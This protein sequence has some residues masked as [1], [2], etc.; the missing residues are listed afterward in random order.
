MS[1]SKTLI[2]TLLAAFMMMAAFF[3]PMTAYA[4][5]P[6]DPV[7]TFDFEGIEG[8]DG[9]DLSELLDS[10]TLDELLEMF[11]SLDFSDFDIE[12]YLNETPTP[13]PDNSKPFTP[14]GQASVLDLA[15][16]G[17]GKMFYTF[18][19]PAGNV[20]YLIIDRQRGGDNVYF[21]SAVTEADLLGLI[22]NANGKGGTST[23][24]IP[25]TPN[26]STPN[27]DGTDENKD[28]ETDVDT[29][30]KKKNNNGMLIFLLI[31]AVAVGGAGYYIKIVRPKQNAGMDDDEDD[32]P[33]EDDG[34]EMEFEDEANE[35]GNEY[36]YTA[37]SDTDEDD[38]DK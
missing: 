31:G 29:P 37:D 5:E 10:F 6:D 2:T 18:K 19:T 36:E 33:D 28:G 3:T 12:N 9:Q 8:F 25:T 7:T 34:E 23:S 11:G 20:F 1:K 38:E 32:I 27:K 17:D 35:D 22:E 16:E 4:E 13:E 24:A 15:Y 26:T 14:D 21:L 30:P